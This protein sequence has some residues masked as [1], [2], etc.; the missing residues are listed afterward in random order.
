[1]RTPDHVRAGGGRDRISDS[2]DGRRDVIGC[3]GG[4]DTVLVASAHGAQITNDDCDAADEFLGC[5]R[6]R[7]AR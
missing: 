3:G 4:V 7:L 6:F 2:R 1:M 5:E